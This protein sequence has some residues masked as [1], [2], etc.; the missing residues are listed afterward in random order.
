[1]ATFTLGP[2]R[3]WTV[4]ETIT[5]YEADLLNHASGASVTTGTVGS[6]S[7]TPLTGLADDKRYIAT[8]GTTEVR[9]VTLTDPDTGGS[10]VP[11]G[12]TTG[13]VLAKT[14]DTDGDA[15]W[16]TIGEGGD[17]VPDAT[18]SVKGLVQLTGD[19]AGTADSPQIATGAIVNA[20]ISGSASIAQSKVSG[21]TTDLAARALS[22]DVDDA[23]DT[24]N[25]SITAL[26]AS[27]TG[28][29]EEERGDREAGDTALDLRVTD[30]E[31]A[32]PGG[33]ASY[34]TVINLGGNLGST[35]K[36]STPT[37]RTSWLAAASSTRTAR[38]P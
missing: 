36:R 23:V 17:P 35:S 11:P 3:G 16:A 31:N 30:L 19:L 29:I 22:T 12:G 6:D 37:A 34:P 14:S 26:S 5:V 13:Q 8:D 10:G 21:L 38:S 25:Q 1:M 18:S 9:F 33:G 28:D 15:D 7:R 32:G 4:G 2:Q 27:V 20:D 24:I